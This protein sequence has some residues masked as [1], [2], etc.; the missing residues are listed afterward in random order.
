MSS[1]RVF[2]VKTV[3]C[4]IIN[5]VAFQSEKACGKTADKEANVDKWRIAF[6]VLPKLIVNLMGEDHTTTDIYL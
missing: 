1:V 5:E 4:S 3:N 6:T 2:S